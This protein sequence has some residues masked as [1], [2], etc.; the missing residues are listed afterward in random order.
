[1][2]SNIKGII[3]ELETIANAF[4]SVKSFQ[5][6]LLSKVNEQPGKTYPLV[7]TES[8]LSGLTIDRRLDLPKKKRYSIRVT[9]YDLFNLT[10]QKTVDVQSA[11]SALEII[12]DQYFAEVN[13]R[14]LNTNSSVGFF[15]NNFEAL[16]GEYIP[17]AH[18]DKLIGIQYLVD[19]NADNLQC[20]KGTFTYV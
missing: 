11:Y 1:M 6:G 14:T 2:A 10:E 13:N 7:H 5:F 18:S 3:D 8:V 20:T 19:F 12:A 17:N 9:F 15:I 4:T 16:R